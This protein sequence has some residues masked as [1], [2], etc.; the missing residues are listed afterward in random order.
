MAATGVWLG[1]TWA[2]GVVE[3]A[4]PARKEARATAV[5]PDKGIGVE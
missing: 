4:V 3:Q 2:V 1:W 5:H